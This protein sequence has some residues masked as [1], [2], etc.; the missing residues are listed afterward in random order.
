MGTIAIDLA[1][2]PKP[3]QPLPNFRYADP[4]GQMKQSS[5]LQGEVVL[6]DFW[7]T[8]CKPCVALL[9]EIE[10]IHELLDDKDGFRLLGLNLDSDVEA[11]KSFLAERDLPWEQGF[12]GT[13]KDAL[14]SL[15]ISSV[16][17]YC[18]VDADGTILEWGSNF[19]NIKARLKTLLK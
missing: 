6:I 9:P 13:K 16:P 1:P 7:A 11:A 4:A 12:L 5:D 2:L 19:E 15:G 14:K 8:W 17:H 3:G 10:E 18:L